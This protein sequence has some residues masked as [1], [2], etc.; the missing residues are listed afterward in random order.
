M[1]EREVKLSARKGFEL[2]D[3]SGTH[4]TV[5]APRTD[6]LLSTVYPDSDCFRLARW[7]LSVRFA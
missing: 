6:E 4:G 3:L 7:G 5:A 1:K 2:P